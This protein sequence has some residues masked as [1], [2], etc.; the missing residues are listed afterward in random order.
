MSA[1][2]LMGT[3]TSM[4]YISGGCTVFSKHSSPIVSLSWEYKINRGSLGK[5][6]DW[7]SREGQS[8]YECIGFS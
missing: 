2:R 4:F 3:F 5:F 7:S 8:D 1:L 6:L